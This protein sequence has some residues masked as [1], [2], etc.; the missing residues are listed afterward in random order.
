MD[1]QTHTHPSV[2]LTLE[3]RP[4][5]RL[6]CSTLQE[7]KPE[8][9]MEQM[10]F[11]EKHCIK[12]YLNSHKCLTFIITCCGLPM[13]ANPAGLRAIHISRIFPY[14]RNSS[15]SSRS[16]IFLG[17]FPIYTVHL[18]SV[19]T[20]EQRRGNLKKRLYFRAS[21]IPKFKAKQ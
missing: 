7:Q 1:T 19:R 8:E 10:S 3:P 16:S 2:S 21:S 5:R 20:K 11:Q 15:S 12:L 4:E 17:K 6:R 9:K 18:L 13:K 14:L